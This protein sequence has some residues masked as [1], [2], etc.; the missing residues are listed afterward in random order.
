MPDREALSSVVRN[1]KRITTK[2]AG[3]EWQR[4]FFDHRLRR[5]ERLSQKAD[6]VINKPRAGRARRK[7]GYVAVRG[8]PRINP[9]RPAHTP[10]RL[11]SI[12]PTS[13]AANTTP[14]R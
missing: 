13:K 2:V 12:A 10:G 11:R 14:C 4:G 1:F 8:H 3:I 5:D 7:R 9:A 6:Y